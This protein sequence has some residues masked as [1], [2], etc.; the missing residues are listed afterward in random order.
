VVLAAGTRLGPYELSELL[1]AGGMGEVYRARDPRLGRDVAVKVIP[2]EGEP[3]GERLRRFEAEARAVAA[4]SHPNVLAVFDVGTDDGRPYVVFELL[5]GETLRSRMRGGAMPLRAAVQVAILVCRGLEAAHARG[6]VHRDLK[7]ENVFIT[8]DGQVKVLDF[9]LAKLTGAQESL[10]PG[11]GSRTETAPGKILGTVG[12]LS[13]EQVRGHEAD[14]RSDLFAL[15]V[16]LYEM[17]SGRHAFSRP[18][19]ADTLSAILHE[20]PPPVAAASGPVPSTAERV[21]RRCLEKRAED[22]FH[23]AHDL[24]LALEALLDRPPVGPGSLEEVEERS[25][26]PGLQAFTEEDAGVFFG[27]EG[28][29]EALWRKLRQRRL[30]AVIGPSG[31]GKTSFVRAGV[32]PARPRGWG[33]IVTT[34][35]RAPLLMLAQALAPAFAGDPEGIKDLLRFE[36]ADVAASTLSRWRHRHASALLVVDQLE[37]LFTLNTPQVQETFAELLGRL[38]N[39]A[40]VCVLLSLRDDFLM[41]CGEQE[42]LSGVFTD[43]TP[44]PSLARPGLRRALV[45]P[46][47]KRGFRFE[48]EALVDEML[49]AVEG[50]RAA[51]PLLAFAVSRLWERRD[52]EKKLLTREAHEAIGGVAGALAQH[53]EQT[54]GR[55]GRERQ[56]TVREIF[57]NL[58]TSQGTRTAAEREEL[59]SVFPER[60]AAEEVLRELIDARLLTSYEVEDALRLP[61]GD[62]ADA[63]DLAGGLTNLRAVRDRDSSTG[64]TIEVGPFPGWEEVPSW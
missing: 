51:L 42:A 50:A 33:A 22:R 2:T 57:R 52:R 10:L 17:L 3:S 49:Q 4:L 60:E 31:A 28:E 19:P 12:Y 14:A 53:A 55:I 1:G 20:D 36:D 11:E 7:P 32:L 13:P 46:A 26:Y 38:A 43:L 56:A 24:A 27:R 40:D 8:R 63:K 9:G 21:A 37:E 25:P 35:G 23:S 6:L 34:P 41:R 58:A 54:L 44:L 29:V 47:R 62:G 15:G 59:L 5:E 30:L 16:V 48:D 64:W 61:E 45:E 18:T 39:E